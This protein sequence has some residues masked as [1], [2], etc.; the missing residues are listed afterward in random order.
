MAS[1]RQTLSEYADAANVELAL[2][3]ESSAREALSSLV[4]YVIA[5]TR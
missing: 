3:P 2:L 5:R 4:R 1:A